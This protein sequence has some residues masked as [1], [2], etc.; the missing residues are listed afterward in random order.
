MIIENTLCLCL[1]AEEAKEHS[2]ACQ[3]DV[4]MKRVDLVKTKSVII[5]QIREMIS[6]CDLTFKAVSPDVS[7]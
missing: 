3:L 5:T 1:Q 7:T 4:S 6:Q 2:A